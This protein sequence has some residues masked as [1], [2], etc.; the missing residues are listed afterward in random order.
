MTNNK[1]EVNNGGAPH[2]VSGSGQKPQPCSSSGSGGHRGLIRNRFHRIGNKA[3]YSQTIVPESTFM[4]ENT[5]PAA[6]IFDSAESYHTND[7]EA[8]NESI[9]G[10]ISNKYEEGPDIS[11]IVLKLVKPTLKPPADPTGDSQYVLRICEK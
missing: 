6:F 11:L 7:S 8:T 9:S 1:P 4:G 5:T 2:V 3:H 10:Y